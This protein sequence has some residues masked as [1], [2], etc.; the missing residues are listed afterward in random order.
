M[1]IPGFTAVRSMNGAT[2]RPVLNWR[3]EPARAAVV[4][5]L[6]SCSQCDSICDLCFDCIDSGGTFGSCRSCGV[7]SYCAPRSCGGGGGGGGGGSCHLRCG[8]ARADCYRTGTGTTV[9]ENQFAGCLWACSS[10]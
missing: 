7:C 2:D 6:P 4:A 9:C 8:E 3:S 5:A 1:S 10:L